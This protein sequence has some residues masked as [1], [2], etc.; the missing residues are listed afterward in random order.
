MYTKNTIAYVRLW[1]LLS[2]CAELACYLL[3]EELSREFIIVLLDKPCQN[4]AKSKVLYKE[5]DIEGTLWNML[6]YKLEANLII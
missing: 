5:L 4:L 3:T 6:L 2:L 1:F